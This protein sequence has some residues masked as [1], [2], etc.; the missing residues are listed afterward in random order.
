MCKKREKL[1]TVSK[2]GDSFSNQMIESGKR[3]KGIHLETAAKPVEQSY[4]RPGANP[5][6][7]GSKC[8]ALLMVM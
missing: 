4:D 3:S 2:G 6:L 1:E 7:I 8:N 5:A